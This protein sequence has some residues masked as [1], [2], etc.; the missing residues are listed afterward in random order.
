MR[1]L[2]TGGA[3]YI[4]S[5]ICVD[6]LEAGH[7]VH[8]ID[9]LSVGRADVMDKIA[10]ICGHS[11]QF[12]KLDLRDAD[13]LQALFSAHQFDAVIHLAG[14]K[15]VA[16]SVARPERYRDVNVGGARRL[17]EAMETHQVFS[18]IFS[19]TA[20]IY[21]EPTRFPLTEDMPSAPVHP[22]AESKLTVENLLRERQRTQSRWRVAILRYFNPVG[23]HPSFLI[24]ERS[25]RGDNLMPKL[26]AAA[27]GEAEL[28]VYGD[29]YPTPDGTAVRD[30]IH[31]MDLSAGHLR[32]LQWLEREQGLL[33][34]NLGT[35]R[36]LS[37]LQMIEAF[38]RAND[39]ELPYSIAPRRPG[40][41]PT[42]L[43]DPSLAERE[44]DWRADL[45]A[46]A[47]CRDSWR[48]AQAERN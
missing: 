16:E 40:D 15:S 31:I 25:G 10:A 13:A 43:A 38:K 46:E 14:L 42:L 1:V 47:M 9:D 39:L 27:A 37:V 36:G 45:G 7:E 22:Y 33:C 29:D 12:S 30:Y 18:M 34:C 23:A 26:C 2:L 21:G 19:S 28:Q 24:G 48:W 5:H 44:L 17:I 6:L 32:A 35:G 4:G 11:P 8:V 20:T 41:V 3:G